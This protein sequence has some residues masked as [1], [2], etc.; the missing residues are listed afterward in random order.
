VEHS[1]PEKGLGSA[2]GE[3]LWD[4]HCWGEEFHWGKFIGKKSRS[5]PDPSE[6]LLLF[7]KNREKVTKKSLAREKDWGE[8][9]CLERGS[10]KKKGAESGGGLLAKSSGRSTQALGANQRS[11]DSVANGGAS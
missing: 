6:S 4:K 10:N 2:S 9:R 3:V 5:E 11:P 7:A 1:W 8:A